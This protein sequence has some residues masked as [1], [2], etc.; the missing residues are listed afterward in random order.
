V[1]SAHGIVRARGL[2]QD[3]VTDGVDFRELPG[4][5]DHERGTAVVKEGRIRVTH[6][7]SEDDVSFVPGAADRVVADVACTQRARQ[8]IEVPRRHLGVEELEQLGAPQGDAVADAFVG[9]GPA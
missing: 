4:P 7:S 8:E 9:A 5:F 6:E 3:R 1:A 2:R